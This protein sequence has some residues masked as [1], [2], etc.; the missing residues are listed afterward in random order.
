[1]DLILSQ[2]WVQ[3]VVRGKSYADSLQFTTLDFHET[4]KPCFL[5][6][7]KICICYQTVIWKQLEQ[8]GDTLALAES[9]CTGTDHLDILTWSPIVIL[10]DLVAIPP[11]YIWQPSDSFWCHEFVLEEILK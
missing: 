11:L 7:N 10:A 6:L 2:T 1:M 8:S 9:T 4:T 5:T 3:I